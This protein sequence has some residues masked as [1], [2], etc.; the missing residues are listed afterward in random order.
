[1]PAD[2]TEKVSSSARIHDQLSCTTTRD[3]NIVGFGESQGRGRAASAEIDAF[4][5]VAISINGTPP[6][7]ETGTLDASRRLVAELNNK[8]SQSWAQPTEVNGAQYIDAE[9]LGVEAFAGRK[10]TIQVV[11]ALT[12][13]E[14]WRSLGYSGHVLLSLPLRSAAEVLKSAI[15]L[16]A[17]KIPTTVR[18]SLTLALDATDVP[19]LSLDA[20]VDEFNE[21]YGKWVETLGFEAVWVVGPWHSMVHKL[22]SASG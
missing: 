17:G 18:P 4:G 5:C 10:L 3:E 1:M 6:R 19:G 14:F 12:D 20:V 7:G 22:C 2:T 15:E 13:P 8:L 16:K 9:A 11:R 21:V